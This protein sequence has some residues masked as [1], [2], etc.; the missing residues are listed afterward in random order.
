[1]IGTIPLGKR[2]EDRFAAPDVHVYRPDLQTILANRAEE[3]K[4]GAIHL[5]SAVAP[6]AEDAYGVVLTLING[7]RVRGD[8][9]IGA[10][11]IRSVVGEEMHVKLKS[12]HTRNVTWQVMIPANKLLPDFRPNIFVNRMGPKI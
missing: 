2:H 10:D 3:P 11:G 5:N 12:N 8:M 4:P 7:E 1:M 6:Y 9:V